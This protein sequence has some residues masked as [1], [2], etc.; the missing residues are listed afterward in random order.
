MLS[1]VLN[2]IKKY[3]LNP[4]KFNRVRFE[5]FREDSEESYELNSITFKLI[6]K[7]LGIK[8]NIMDEK[9]LFNYLSIGSSDT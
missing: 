2:I 6:Y 8:T 9:D 5:M 7:R 4:Q 1:R 3:E